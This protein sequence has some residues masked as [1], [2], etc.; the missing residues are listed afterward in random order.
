MTGTNCIDIVFLHELNVKQHIFLCD[1]SA[2][3]RIKFVSI[4]P[5]END[6]FPIQAHDSVFQFKSAESDFGSADLD[7]IS[8]FV[9]QNHCKCVE[10]RYFGTPRL[11]IFK[12]PV[13]GFL[14][15]GFCNDRSILICQD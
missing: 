2:C 9:C 8:A 4:N 15:I 6:T 13:Y 5:L 12:L 10:I 7:F 11:A 1:C 14:F 3:F